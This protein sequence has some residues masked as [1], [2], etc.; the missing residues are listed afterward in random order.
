MPVPLVSFESVVERAPDVIVVAAPYEG[1]ESQWQGA[2][3]R[4][5]WDDRTRQ[6]NASLITRPSLRMLEGIR[7]L[8]KTLRDG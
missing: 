8:C 4:L 2:W 6:I 1:F 3:H 7:S 5:G